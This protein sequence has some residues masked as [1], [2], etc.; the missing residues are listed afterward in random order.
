MNVAAPPAIGNFLLP[1]FACRGSKV[2]DRYREGV[3]KHT[4]SAKTP[5]NEY[6]LAFRGAHCA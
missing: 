1:D 4:F 6:Y 2:K 5:S 3:L